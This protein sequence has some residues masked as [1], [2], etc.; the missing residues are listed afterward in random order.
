MGEIKAPGVQVSGQTA[1]AITGPIARYRAKSPGAN[2]YRHRAAV[3]VRTLNSCARNLEETPP[4]LI[5]TPAYTVCPAAS[6]MSRVIS[7]GWEINDRWLDFTSMV[8]API[9]LA[10]NRWGSGLIVRSSVETA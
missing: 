2:E 7:S 4:P 5:F 3:L 8:L 1:P 9:R 6:R 10:M